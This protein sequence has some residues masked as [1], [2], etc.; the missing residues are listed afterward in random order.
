MELNSYFNDLLSNIRLPEKTADACRKA[1]EHLR[2]Q[3]QDDPDLSKILVAIFL[4]GSYRRATAIRPL[5]QKKSDIDVVLVTRLSAG[6]Y[7]PQQAFEVF[8]PF[9]DRHYAGKYSIQGRSIGIHLDEVDLDMVITAAPSESEIGILKSESVTAWQSLEALSDWR[10]HPAW[11][12]GHLSGPGQ[13]PKIIKSAISEPEWKVAPLLIPD[14]E[15]RRWEPTHP[16]AQILWTRD[17]NARCN[18]NYL[19]V[20]RAIKWWHRRNDGMPKHPKGYL[21]EHL[22]GVC[23]PD[24]IRSVAEGVTRTLESVA[25][26]YESDVA[27][28][29]VPYLPDHGVPEHNVFRRITPAEFAAFYGRATEAAP[30]ARAALESTEV[31]PSATGWKALFGDDFPNPP[32]DG[33]GGPRGPEP[34]TG[35]FTPRAAPTVIGGSRWGAI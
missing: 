27:M 5:H 16:L 26:V 24:S 33:G 29:R 28:G 4:Q 31:G 15:A 1:H 11:S 19:G 34:K 14:R 10:L 13:P 2:Q 22:V 17:K 32:A 21:I 20:V 6:E 25:K 3:I 35:G 12:S 23:C 9:L 30:I 18:G 7:T 8:R